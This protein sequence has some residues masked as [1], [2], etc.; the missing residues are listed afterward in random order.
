MGSPIPFSHRNS[1]EVWV[2]RVCLRNIQQSKLTKAHFGG[3]LIWHGLANLPWWKFNWFVWLTQ[4][5]HHEG[6]DGSNG[7]QQTHRPKHFLQHHKLFLSWFVR[8]SQSSL[9][10]SCVFLFRKGSDGEQHTANI[11]PI[12]S[13]LRKL[14][15]QFLYFSSY[16]VQLCP[17]PFLQTFPS[18]ITI[19][20]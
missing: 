6:E 12:A 14:I 7:K 11:F 19:L 20:A 18:L 10:F 3:F 16:F 17:F 15:D 1:Q 13:E 4:S 5:L 2:G 8:R 9:K